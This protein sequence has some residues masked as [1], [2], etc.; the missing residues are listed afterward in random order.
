MINIMKIMLMIY[1][2][3]DYDSFCDQIYYDYEFYDCF[4]DYL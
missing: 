3:Y 2:Y 4:F 1:D